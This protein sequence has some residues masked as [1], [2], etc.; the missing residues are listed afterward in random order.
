[1]EEMEGAIPGAVRSWYSEIKNDYNYEKGKG[2]GVVRY[3]QAV[4]WKGEERV[5]C[6][7]NVK[8]NDG[9]YVTAHYA[10]A[11]H[12]HDDV[13]K[14]APKNV[15][16]RKGRAAILSRGRRFLYC[17]TKTLEQSS[18]RTEKCSYNFIF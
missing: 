8:E 10:P 1:M 3:F 17:G 6:G 18:Q 5:G 16:P 14:L 15:L 12:A 4:V 2:E 13:D 11:S 7:L 9:T